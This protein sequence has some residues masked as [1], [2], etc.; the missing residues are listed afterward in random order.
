MK[1]Q[2]RTPEEIKSKI[3]EALSKNVNYTY[4]I[5]L[6]VPASY[7]TEKLFSQNIVFLK[8]ATFL[9]ALE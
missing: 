2:K 5:I 3:F 8:D 4:E 7:L 6:G 1:W 9:S